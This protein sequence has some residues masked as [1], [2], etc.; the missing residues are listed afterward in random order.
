V[1]DISFP[2]PAEKAFFLFPFSGSDYSR[3][4]QFY[5]GTLV[6]HISLYHQYGVFSRNFY[7]PD[8]ILPIK[9]YRQGSSCPVKPLS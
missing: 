7:F 2:I 4:F 5:P 9:P 3:A 1:L 6:K 8:K